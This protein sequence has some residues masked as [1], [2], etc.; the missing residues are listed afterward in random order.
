MRFVSRIKFTYVLT[1]LCLIFFV[2]IGT[3]L[4]PYIRGPQPYPKEWQWIYLFSNPGLKI[5][6]PLIILIAILKI[7]SLITKN[8][9]KLFLVLL[10]LTFLFQISL[11][12]LGRGGIG[13]VF[14]RIVNPGA[15]GYFTVS[16]KTK[17]SA[18]PGFLKNYNSN[19]LSFPMH[20]KSHTPGTIIMFSTL[21]SVYS[22][23]PVN[24]FI[25]NLKPK[26]KNDMTNNWSSLKQNQKV[27]AITSGFI[28]ILL[29]ILGSILIFLSTSNFYNKNVGI[30]SA[31]LYLTIPSLN[32]FTGLPDA[33]Y[34]TIALISLFMFSKFK[35]TKKPIY[36]FL[37]GV[38]LFIALFFSLSTL[39]I[40][41]ILG[42]TYSLYFYKELS[43]IHHLRNFIATAFGLLVLPLILFVF[44]K[45]NFLEIALTI[46][47]HLPDKARSY[48]L[49]LVF[50][51]W[52][53]FLF[54]GIP[55]TI[56]F[57]YAISKS[58]KMKQIF[59]KT[60][61]L[62]ISFLITFIML[63]IAGNARG[64]VGRIWITL[65]PFLI[66]GTASLA[67]KTIFKNHKQ[68]FLLLIFLQLTQTILMQIFWVTLW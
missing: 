13:I 64:E 15:N 2:L 44:F 22:I 39:P 1:F 50:N 18:L 19:V 61:F 11:L 28:L 57:I 58:L 16:T 40:L 6:A 25:T 29:G 66:I 68:L 47:N 43:F 38:S 21:N 4:V 45:F 53:F 36:L 56:V 48:P 42:I 20:A 27:T 62:L 67:E 34:S 30:K 31:I 8:M 9:T 65:M 59:N 12:F 54:C 60:N 49:W 35:I 52:D 32:L 10:L 33:L 3:D 14:N 41:L 7:S 37:T 51:I 26:N 55:V 17:L 63:D 23:L 5:I 24:N 46:M